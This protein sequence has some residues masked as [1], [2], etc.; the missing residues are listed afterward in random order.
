MNKKRILIL[1]IAAAALLAGA[2][3][4]AFLL[5]YPYFRKYAAQNGISLREARKAWGRPDKLSE[6]AM[7]LTV[8]AA[9]E[10][11]DAVA[12]LAAEG[13]VKTVERA[14]RDGDLDGAELVLA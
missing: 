11:W 3:Q 13:R 4:A 8:E 7:G 9:L 2:S 1:T 10:N 6:V 14:Y 12:A 5:R